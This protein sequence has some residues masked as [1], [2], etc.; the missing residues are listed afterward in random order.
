M[1]RTHRLGQTKEVAEIQ[2]L[3]TLFA[4]LS[5]LCFWVII[6]LSLGDTYHEKHMCF[7]NLTNLCVI[8]FLWLACLTSIKLDRS[9]VMKKLASLTLLYPLLV[10]IPSIQFRLKVSTRPPPYL[11]V[12]ALGCVVLQQ[13]QTYLSSINVSNLTIAL[14]SVSCTKKAY[15]WMLIHVVICL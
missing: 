4:L 6:E 11:V 2:F 12:F 10:I 15:L 3:L 9:I 7:R 5:L 14:Q 8:F 1:D 13:S